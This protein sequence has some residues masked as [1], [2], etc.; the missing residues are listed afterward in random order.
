MSKYQA[1]IS[2]ADATSLRAAR[3]ITYNEFKKHKR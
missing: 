2:I 3:E 1:T